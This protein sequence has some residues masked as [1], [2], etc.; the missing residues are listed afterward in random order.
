MPA[1]DGELVAAEL[2]RALGAPGREHRFGVVVVDGA[3]SR[4]WRTY[5]I[6]P[7]TAIFRFMTSDRRNARGLPVS[8]HLVAA[9]PNEHRLSEVM[10]RLYYEAQPDDGD[11]H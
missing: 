6:P 2:A 11:W 5:A 3:A 8:A 4:Y 9:I 1:N 10:R 7:Y